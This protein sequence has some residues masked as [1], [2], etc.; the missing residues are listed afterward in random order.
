MSQ[1]EEEQ[2]GEEFNYYIIEDGLGISHVL[3][4]SRGT[5]PSLRCVDCD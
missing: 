4:R 5:H 3:R 1:E 2:K